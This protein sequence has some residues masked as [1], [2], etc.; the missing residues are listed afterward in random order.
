MKPSSKFFHPGKPG[1][2]TNKATSTRGSIAPA[3]LFTLNLGYRLP[4]VAVCI[5]IFWQSSFPSLNSQPL[6]PLDDK[7][8]HIGAYAFLAFLAARN[9]KQ[10]KPFFS[11]TKLMVFAILFAALYGLSDEIHQAFVPART[12]SFWDFAADTIGSILGAFF[13]FYVFHH[14]K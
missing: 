5:F 9:L 2:K 1:H 11:Q 13:Y 8:M 3:S 14:K 4:V 7:V 6:F 12:A 10:E